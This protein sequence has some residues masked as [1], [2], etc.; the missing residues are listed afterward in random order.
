M[1]AVHPE[2]M[3]DLAKC[4]FAAV[5]VEMDSGQNRQGM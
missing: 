4:H 2:E 5:R 1:C 3:M